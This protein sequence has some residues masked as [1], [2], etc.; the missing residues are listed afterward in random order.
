[1]LNQS[2]KSLQELH[3]GNAAPLLIADF[4]V[5]RVGQL[6]P[7]ANADNTISVTIRT[8]AALLVGTNVTVSGLT[9]S[10]TDDTNLDVSGNGT[11]LVGTSAS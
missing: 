9:G 4:L 5:K 1:M 3:Q 6:T 11:V 7:S 8:R 2:S 10:L